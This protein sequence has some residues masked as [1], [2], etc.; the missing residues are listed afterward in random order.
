MKKWIKRII[1]LA[2]IAALAVLIYERVNQK[3]EELDTRPVPTVTTAN[4]ERGDIA[5]DTSI[6]G[7]VNPGSTFNVMPKTAGAILEV[8]V[9]NGDT[10]VKDQ[11]IAHIDNQDAIDSARNSLDS[12]TIQLKSAEDSLNRTTPLYQAGDVSASD[13]ESLTTQVKSLAASVRSARLAYDI[14]SENAYVLAPADGVIQNADM[15]VN[16]TVSPSSQLCVVTSTGAKTMNFNV[17]D[18]VMKNLTVGQEVTV[19]KNGTDYTG[20]ITKIGTILNQQ[21]GLYAVEASLEN[22]D[23]IADGSTARVKFTTDHAENVLIL[24]VDDLYYSAGQPYVYLYQDGRA[25]ETNVTLGIQNDENV[26][27]TGGI[28][29]NSQIITSWSAQL[30]NGASVNLAEETETTAAAETN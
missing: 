21:T 20:T 5:H 14:Q 24:P 15:T 29:E 13:Y 16:E 1:I 2:V 26:E 10:V 22:A 11:R 9:Q 8:F 28:D 30:Y 4:P 18:D 12:A 7:T 3:P 27:I 23:A 19:S 6:M 25:V 17:T